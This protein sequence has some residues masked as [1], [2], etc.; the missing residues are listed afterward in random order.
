MLAEKI[1]NVFLLD[2]KSGAKVDTTTKTFI[3]LEQF[4][5]MI[6]DEGEINIED[7][8][9]LCNENENIIKGINHI[10]IGNM[11]FRKRA[12]ET[13]KVANTGNTIMD[14]KI[15]FLSGFYYPLKKWWNGLTI[16]ERDA[17]L[18]AKMIE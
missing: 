1:H 7:V 5:D 14:F 11:G 12:L 4:N 17:I 15:R 2:V 9:K 3:F 16:G 10:V 8:K 13:F 18:D 6:N